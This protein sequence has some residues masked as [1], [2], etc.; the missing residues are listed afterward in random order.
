DPRSRSASGCRPADGDTASPA[1]SV[2][3]R[4]PALRT[5]SRPP[6]AVRPRR[7][8]PSPA[9]VRPR[10]MLVTYA[11]CPIGTCAM[12]TGHPAVGGWQRAWATGPDAGMGVAL[13]LAVDGN[14]PSLTDSKER[15]LM[16]SL[17]HAALAGLIAL[18]LSACQKDAAEQAADVADARRDAAQD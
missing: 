3:S 8:A 13:V 18:S 14:A 2:A 15:H 11:R 7:R 1:G 5:I 17:T 4:P 10:P 12:R 9:I 16:K 6:D